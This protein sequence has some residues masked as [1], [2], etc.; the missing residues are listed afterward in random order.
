MPGVELPPQLVVQRCIQG[1]QLTQTVY[2]AARLGVADLLADG[3]LTSNALAEATDADPAAL[4]RLLLALVAA[5]LLATES[6]GRFV[7]TAAGQLLRAGVPGSARNRALFFG[8]HATWS[9]W[10]SLLHCVQTGEPAYPHVFGTDVWQY[11]EQHPET[12]ALF[13]N[14]MSELTAMSSAALVR[15]YDFASAGTVVDVGGGHGRMLASILQ[16]FLGIRGVLFDLPRTVAG[17]EELA[18]V[19]DRCE[20]VGGDLF[21]EVPA[22]YD[23]YLLSRV[24]HDWDDERTVDI[25][26]RCRRAM[27]PD[28]KVL[29]L[30]RV[31]AGEPDLASALSDLTM[32]V[33]TGGR[34]RT[35]DEFRALLS[36]AGLRVT[37]LTPVLHGLQVIESVAAQEV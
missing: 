13:N 16:A 8:D 20:V 22:G 11:R 18:A 37:A 7:L 3:P 14:I 6:D 25:L 2:A 33:G 23:T 27:K 32:L 1:F 17:A 21:G 10:G 28:G 5:D 35:G 30:E 24:V 12:A 36:R 9:V 29:L 19:R 34:E 4:H 26:A 31:V 15:A